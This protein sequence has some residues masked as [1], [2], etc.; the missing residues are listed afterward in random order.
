MICGTKGDLVEDVER[1]IRNMSSDS[2]GIFINVMQL[3][4]CNDQKGF[5]VINFQKELPIHIPA[6]LK[7][8]LGQTPLCSLHHPPEQ[9]ISKE[10]ISNQDIMLQR[11]PLA[12]RIKVLKRGTDL[13]SS[14][15]WCGCLS[16]RQGLRLL[17]DSAEC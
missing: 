5:I 4:V 1:Q 15:C 10:D 17:T 9:L 8:S 13:L 11:H 7:L 12:R 2:A 16:V 14:N 6:I 3:A